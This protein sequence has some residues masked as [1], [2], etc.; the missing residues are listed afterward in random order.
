M[1]DR[2]QRLIVRGIM[3]SLHRPTGH[4]V[5]H[6]V[7][8]FP[9]CRRRPRHPVTE[10]DDIAEILDEAARKWP[11]VPRAKLIHLVLADWAA[12]ARSKCTSG[13]PNVPRWLIAGHR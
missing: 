1:A 11:D 5:L 3:P 13:R 6:L 4:Q 9:S 7:L 2:R 10:T 8:H 12:G